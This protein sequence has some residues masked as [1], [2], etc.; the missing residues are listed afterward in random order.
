VSKHPGPFFLWGRPAFLFLW[1][2]KKE[3]ASFAFFFLKVLL[4]KKK[5][6]TRKSKNKKAGAMHQAG[7]RLEQNSL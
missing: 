4:L 6:D 3:K 7:V 1:G 5:K 2:I